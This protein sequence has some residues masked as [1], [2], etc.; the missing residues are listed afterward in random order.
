MFTTEEKYNW[1]CK[2]FGEASIDWAEGDDGSIDFVYR[3]I[4]D[5]DMGITDVDSYAW[6]NTLLG[7]DIGAERALGLIRWYHENYDSTLLDMVIV[8]SKEIFRNIAELE[9]GYHFDYSKWPEEDPKYIRYDWT[10]NNG[11]TELAE[12]LDK[13]YN[14]FDLYE[15]NDNDWSFDKTKKCLDEDPYA[16]ISDLLDILEEICD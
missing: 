3:S 1:L 13:F 16:I 11:N 5:Y 8:D 14:E 9:L 15:Y 10:V 4:R 2:E 7:Y 6:I 12:R